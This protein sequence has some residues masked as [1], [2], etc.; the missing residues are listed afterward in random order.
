V[1]D[2][3]LPEWVFKGQTFTVSGHVEYFDAVTGI[4][5]PIDAPMPITIAVEDA[6]TTTYD[7]GRGTADQTVNADY[8]HFAINSAVPGAA[9]SGHMTVLLQALGNEYYAP[10]ELRVA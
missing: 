3:T 1:L 7:I 4:W 2:S 10:S 9:P 6:A 8:G 5:L